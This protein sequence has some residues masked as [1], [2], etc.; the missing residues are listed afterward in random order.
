MKNAFPT[1]YWVNWNF[2]L[3]GG[4]KKKGVPKKASTKDRRFF[5]P[6]RDWGGVGFFLSI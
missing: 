3:M 2:D 6:A 5:R 1:L 4:L